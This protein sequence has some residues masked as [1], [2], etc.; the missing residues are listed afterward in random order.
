VPQAVAPAAWCGLPGILGAQRAPPAPATE[1]VWAV[2][3]AVPRPL[4]GKGERN[5]LP[6]R[7]RLARDLAG[8]VEANE[9]ELATGFHTTV[10]DKLDHGWWSSRHTRR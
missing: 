8:L 9:I 4:V 1:A 5:E 6:A 10:I 3:Q 2:H 7:G